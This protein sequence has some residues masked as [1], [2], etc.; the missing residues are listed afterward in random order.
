[1]SLKN[2]YNADKI[3]PTPKLNVIRQAIGNN[4]IIK[5]HSMGIPSTITNTKKMQSVR[6]KLIREETFFDIRKRYFGT[7]G[8]Q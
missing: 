5:C 4:S 2:T 6:P 7:K 1:M 3:K 8:Q